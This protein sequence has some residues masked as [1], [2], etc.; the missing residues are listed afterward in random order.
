MASERRRQRRLAVRIDTYCKGA[1]K[2]DIGNVVSISDTG[3]GVKFENMTASLNDQFG[4]LMQ[5]VK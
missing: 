5:T 3:A 1:A 2:A 4:E